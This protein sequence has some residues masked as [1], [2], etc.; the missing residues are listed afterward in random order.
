MKPTV[1]VILT[2]YNHEKY[3]AEAIESVLNQTFSD[4][5]LL[6]ADDG[7]SDNSREVI[8]KFSDTR[9]KIFLHENNRGPRIILQELLNVAQGK[10]IAIHH[11]DDTWIAD[12]L[13][14]QINFLDANKNYAACFTWANFI[15]EQGNLQ[16][17]ADEDFYKK[18]FEQENKSRAEWL[19]YFFFNQNCLCHPSLM[20]RKNIYKKYNLTD[21]N[22]LWQIPDF[23]MWIKFCFHEN[24]Y[25]MPERLVNFRL[26]RNSQEN[27]SAFSFEKLSRAESETFLVMQ[28]FLDNF[29]DDKFFLE[30]FPEAEK[31]VVNGEFNRNFSF[32]QICFEKNQSLYHL[33]ALKILRELLSDK[34]S[35][36]QI[37]KLYDYDEKKFYAD[38]GR[39]DIFNIAQKFSM[40][41]AKIY[42]SHDTE[43]FT[44]A[45]EKFI[46]VDDGARFF[47]KT[48]FI[49]DKPIK[50]LRFDPDDNFISI[51][52]DSVKICGVEQKTF[53]N[54]FA[55]IVNGFY[56]FRTN[57][58]QFI[59][60]TDNLS[61]KIIFEVHGKVERNYF[62]ILG[63]DFENLNKQIKNSETQISS[64]RKILT[65]LKNSNS[66]KI[67]AP[68]R[69]IAEFIRR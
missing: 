27:T 40:L 56:R 21:F 41:R 50:Y 6:I 23:Y 11:S 37:K 69:K 15:D 3:I 4:F 5:E 58:P 63:K 34:N 61:G 65:E 45:S 2:S 42:Y 46:Y 10:Y 26:R 57:D 16:E 48:E 24:F 55:E 68:L 36:E 49:S 38:T 28:N 8:K 7:S 60:E 25:I 9:I 44:L 31:F 29:K 18:I 52:I 67:T 64:M 53:Q 32:A 47:F 20:I 19:R 14:K 33:I 54:N 43:N 66:W 17:L 62:D 13:E 59:F 30:V 22:G 12:K 51:K 39:F 35:A 1:S